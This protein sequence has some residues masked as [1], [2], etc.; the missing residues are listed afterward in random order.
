MD[1]RFTCNN[2]SFFKNKAMSI[3]TTALSS[4]MPHPLY[5]WCKSRHVGDLWIIFGWEI[6]ILFLRSRDS[7]R[8]TFGNEIFV[9]NYLFP[10]KT[11]FS[12]QNTTMGTQLELQYP[13][14]SMRRWSWLECSL[15]NATHKSNINNIGRS[16]TINLKLSP[17]TKQSQSIIVQVLQQQTD[18]SWYDSQDISPSQ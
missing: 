15:E 16:C 14:Q 11:P 3:K 17:K 5:S 1:T 4:N 10:I 12:H 18:Q 9:G 7:L 2:I 8:K 6:S 13:K